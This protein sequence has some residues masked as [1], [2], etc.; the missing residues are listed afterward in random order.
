MRC[1]LTRMKIRWGRVPGACAS[2]S[3]LIPEGGRYDYDLTEKFV[4]T[5]CRARRPQA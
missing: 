2:I 1:A 4:N 3:S 5:F